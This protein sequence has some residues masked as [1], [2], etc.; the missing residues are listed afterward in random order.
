MSYTAK[1]EFWH[2]SLLQREIA[3]C[4]YDKEEGRL[5]GFLSR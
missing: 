5:L 1:Q 4:S 2:L 3:M